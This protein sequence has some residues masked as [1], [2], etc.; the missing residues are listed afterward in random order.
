MLACVLLFGCGATPEPARQADCGGPPPPF[1]PPFLCSPTDP[2]PTAKHPAQPSGC[3]TVA[4]EP[5]AGGGLRIPAQVVC[6][7]A[8]GTQ[9]PA[10]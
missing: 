6:P 8:A 5:D 1:S 9:R 10:P 7:V 4:H 3:V 2:E